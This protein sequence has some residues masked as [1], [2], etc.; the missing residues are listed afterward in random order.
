M[1]QEATLIDADRGIGLGGAAYGRHVVAPLVGQ[2]AFVAGHA[3]A[4]KRNRIE[5]PPIGRCLAQQQLGFPGRDAGHRVQPAPLIARAFSRSPSHRAIVPHAPRGDVQPGA[6]AQVASVVGTSAAHV[7]RIVVAGIAQPRGSDAT[8][9]QGRIHI[10]AGASRTQV[11]GGHGQQQLLFRRVEP[12]LC[13]GN[14][15][16]QIA[17]IGRVSQRRTP[18]LGSLALKLFHVEPRTAQQFD[19]VARRRAI[20]ADVAEFHERGPAPVSVHQHIDAIL[21]RQHGVR[22]FEPER[23]TESSE[24]PRNNILESNCTYCLDLPCACASATMTNMQRPAIQT[25][26]C[27]DLRLFPGRAV[28]CIVK[29]IV[30]ALRKN[31]AFRSARQGNDKGR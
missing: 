9:R 2:H 1:D 17:A 5:V 29:C 24:T 27:R 7:L 21:T 16:S 26:R 10:D 31:G 3:H 18:L 6:Q 11:D 23:S 13:A 28:T 22:L 30:L 19:G 14:M 25:R 20:L 8:V 12:G 15:G 4:A